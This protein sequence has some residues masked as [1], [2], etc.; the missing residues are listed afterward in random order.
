MSI[1]FSQGRKNCGSYDETGKREGGGKKEKNTSWPGRG[2]ENNFL[3]NNAIKQLREA[4]I[5]Q[6]EGEE[7]GVMVRGTTN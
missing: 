7:K 4:L 5:V 3:R 1:T 6:Q 2:R